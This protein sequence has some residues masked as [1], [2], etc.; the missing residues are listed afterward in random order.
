MKF[1]KYNALELAKQISLGFFVCITIMSFFISVLSLL[2]LVPIN[3]NDNYY[4]G[5]RGM[6]IGILYIPLITLAVSLSTIPFILGGLWI[7]KTAST[8][9]GNKI[10]NGKK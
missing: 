6:C 8:V 4:T 9:F 5:I 7:A 2:D 3:F 10:E 1:L